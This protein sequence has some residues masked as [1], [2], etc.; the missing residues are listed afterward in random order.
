MSSRRWSGR[1]QSQRR[2]FL[3]QR[4][5]KSKRV[6]RGRVKGGR[7]EEEVAKDGR[8][9]STW[10][11]YEG[12]EWVEL[13]DRWMALLA[14]HNLND[15]AREIAEL[16]NNAIQTMESETGAGVF[17]VFESNIFQFKLNL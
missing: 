12:V 6:R 9:Y 13:D 7:E 1:A 4:N 11:E 3:Q 10:D 8:Y 17:A 16:V 14:R 5:K 15:I 2:Y